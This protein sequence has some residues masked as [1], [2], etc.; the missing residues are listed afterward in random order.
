[1][2]SHSVRL[3]LP[4]F[5]SPL[6]PRWYELQH[7]RFQQEACLVSWVADMTKLEKL[8]VKWRDLFRV[9]CGFRLLGYRWV[10]IGCFSLT[11]FFVIKK[12]PWEDKLA[13]FICVELKKWLKKE[14]KARVWTWRVCAVVV[15][16]PWT[17][18]FMFTVGSANSAPWTAKRKT[19]I[20]A[21]LGE[22]ITVLKLCHLWT[23]AN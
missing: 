14:K 6:H 22:V 12:K 17:A 20:S 18:N 7:D 9:R 1:M 16:A 2:I 10:F 4:V 11:F 13:F 19:P 21:D 23:E 15:S 5:I 3:S 8:G